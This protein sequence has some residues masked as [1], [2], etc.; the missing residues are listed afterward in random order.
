MKA[1]RE[2]CRVEKQAEKDRDTSQGGK[3]AL[4]TDY[5]QPAHNGEG[6]SGREGRRER[7]DIDKSRADR[8]RLRDKIERVEVRKGKIESRIRTRK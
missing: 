8:T 3:R 4:W 7:R 6:K 2:G 1:A 5:Q